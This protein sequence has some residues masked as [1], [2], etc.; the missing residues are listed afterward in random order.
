ML[1]N[2]IICTYWCLFIVMLITQ[3]GCASITKQFDKPLGASIAEIT[4]GITHYYEV[5]DELGPPANISSLADGFAFEYETLEINEQQFG[6]SSSM[7]V[8][9]WFKL[10]YGKAKVSREVRTVIFNKEGYVQAYGKK[11]LNEDVGSG[12]SFQFIVKVTQIVDTSYLEKPSTPN[13]WGFSLLKPLPVGLN[14]VQSLDSGEH[15]LEQRGTPT[16]IGQRTLEF[17]GVR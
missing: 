7:D 6:I 5:L 1:R 9:R 8:I 16:E 4:P 11:Q 2:N 14:R 12:M 13:A 10:A 17:Y 15:G 3:V